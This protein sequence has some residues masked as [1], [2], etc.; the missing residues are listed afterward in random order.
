MRETIANPT[1]LVDVTGFSH[2]IEDVQGDLK[3]GASVKNTT[4]AA[5]RRVRERF[6]L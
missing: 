1:L 4:V 3:I 6:P 2:E 5:D